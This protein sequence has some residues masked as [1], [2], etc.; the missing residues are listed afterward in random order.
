[1]FVR[2]VCACVL[3]VASPA[4]AGAAH[5]QAREITAEEA[6]R[7]ALEEHLDIRAAQAEVEVARGQL[8]AARTLS[9]NPEVTAA[10]GSASNPDTSLTS[11][12]VE[13]SQRLELGGKRGARTTAAR[14]R[15]DAAEARLA[16]TRELVAARA[17]RA[18]ALA[19]LGRARVASTEEAEQVASELKR[20]ATDRLALGAGTQ[21]E[22]NVAAAGVGR[23]RRARLEAERAYASALL[24]LGAAVGLPAVQSVTPVGG[25][26]AV[27]PIEKSEEDLVQLA[28]ARRHD[29]RAATA[30][31]AAA[32][33]D[34]RFA[35]ALSWPDPAFGVSAG[36]DDFEA[37]RFTIS[38]PLPLWNR[39]QGERST[40]RAA[41]LRA[42]LAESTVR[43][44][45]E[46]EV[47]DAY[48]AYQRA[49]EA[50]SG[51]DRETVTNLSENITLAGESFQA[52]KIGLL[53]FSAVRRDLVEARLAYLDT[54]VD[55]AERRYALE[56]AVGGIVE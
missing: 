28:V 23:D 48:Q 54:L 47:R 25:P 22:L 4:L 56:L 14:R 17:V 5:A 20:A 29:L 45:V 51:F 31:R 11:Y 13:L 36:R 39:G 38:L 40:A 18:F 34:L 19:S 33:A 10:I 37:V 6:V 35:R 16:R 12:E 43:R 24:E 1:M 50:E 2:A 15:V 27:T 32:G 42:E 52:G 30:E 3:V 21:L 55:L 26:P 41:L 46:L 44:Q 8:A 7:R 9:Y 49:R 53:V